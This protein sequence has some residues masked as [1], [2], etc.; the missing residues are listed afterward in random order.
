M[1]RP[2]WSVRRT[3][4]SAMPAQVK[5]RKRGQAPVKS[6]VPSA[7]IEPATTAYRANRVEPCAQSL[8]SGLPSLVDELSSDNCRVAAAWSFAT[9]ATSLPLPHGSR[10]QDVP[11][12]SYEDDSFDMV[13]AV[14]ASPWS[15]F[16]L[17]ARKRTAS[18]S[19]SCERS[20][21]SRMLIFGQRH[22][23]TLLS[24]YVRHYNTQQ[25]HR[26]RQ[27]RLPQPEHSIHDDPPA[28]TV[29]RPI[30]GGLI[31]EYERAA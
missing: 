15:R 28:H 21:P 27:R 7:G 19:A 25:P 18:P 12:A 3:G 26:S 6:V 2:C 17:A 11:V 24:E 22:L 9:D 13:P 30:L 1:Q 8:F 10:D 20:E 23:R 14:R 5:R 31:N 4:A 16:R 29:R